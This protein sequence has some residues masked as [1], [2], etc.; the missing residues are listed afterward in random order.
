MHTCK[1]ACL[2]VKRQLVFF[3]IIKQHSFDHYFAKEITIGYCC[4]MNLKLYKLNMFCCFVFYTTNIL[5]TLRGIF[6][7]PRILRENGINS[8]TSTNASLLKEKVGM[9]CL[10]LIFTNSN[11]QSN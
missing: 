1:R 3:K 11:L 4:F 2:R 8:H 6:N 9:A 5:E 7:Q 10:E